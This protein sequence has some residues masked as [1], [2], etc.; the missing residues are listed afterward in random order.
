[1]CYHPCFVSVGGL[2]SA[3]HAGWLCAFPDEPPHLRPF[4]NAKPS[5]GVNRCT[6]AKC[7]TAVGIDVLTLAVCDGLLVTTVF[8]DSPALNRASGDVILLWQLTGGRD[9]TLA[10]RAVVAQF[11]PSVS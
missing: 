1:M 9:L 11:V 8:P 7:S 2:L 4:A 5:V 10:G 3:A 6:D